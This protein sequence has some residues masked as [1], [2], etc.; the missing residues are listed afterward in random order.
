[1]GLVD[2]ELKLETL[3][4]APLPPLRPRTG[5][6]RLLLLTSM[7]EGGEDEL[8]SI[9]VAFR[10]SARSLADNSFDRVRPIFFEGC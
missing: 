5:V 3:P 7:G 1:M 2:A 6:L 8:E 10:L 4:L 9:C